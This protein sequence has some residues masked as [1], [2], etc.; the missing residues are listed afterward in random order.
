MTEAEAPYHAHI[1]Y[2]DAQ[3]AAA[4]A[5]RDQFIGLTA[6]G[7]NPHIRFVGQMVDRGVGP[8]PVPQYEIHFLGA[9]RSK[10]VAAIDATG[11]RALVHPLTHDDLADH[12]SLGHWIGKPIKLDLA[13]LDPP[14]KNQGMPRFGKADF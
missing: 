5:L 6:P 13:V 7:S 4:A 14:G 3:R 12:T 9:A 11:L 2:D 8:H 1:Y 10:V